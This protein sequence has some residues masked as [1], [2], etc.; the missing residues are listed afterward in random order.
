M[1]TLL[2]SR[3]L[4]SSRPLT[5]GEIGCFLSHCYMWKEVVNR[6]LEKMLVIEDNVCFEHQF[7]RK[8]MKLMG[9]IQQ[10]QLDWELIYIGWKRMQV[11]EPEKAVPNVTILVEADYSYWMLGYAVSFQG[12]QKL[13]RAAPFSK[14]LPVDE[15]LPV[16]YNKHP[17]SRDLKTFSAEPLLETVSTDWNRTHSWKSHQQGKI[18][19]D[20]QKKDALPSQSPLN[21]PSSRGEQ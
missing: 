9:D 11:Q 12:A 8:L 5:R 16:M 7:K 17:E 15:F 21:A 20:A 1:D 10:A 6:E 4:Y 18:H 14:M 19:S 3:D 2:G 13:I